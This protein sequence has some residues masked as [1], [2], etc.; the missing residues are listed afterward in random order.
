MCK[1]IPYPIRQEAAQ[2]KGGE[3]TEKKFKSKNALA[4]MT[5]NNLGNIKSHAVTFHEDVP[6]DIP[7]LHESFVYAYTS[8]S[9]I[10]R[11]VPAFLG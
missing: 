5:E 8:E 7:L 2:K 4:Q 1:D 3:R 10:Y 9:L 6:Q 11:S